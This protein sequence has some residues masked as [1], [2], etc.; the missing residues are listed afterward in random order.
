MTDKILSVCVKEDE[1]PII[2]QKLMR[3]GFNSPS[4]L[5][6]SIALILSHPSY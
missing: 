2:N 6:H 1:L 3:W 4:E 5:M